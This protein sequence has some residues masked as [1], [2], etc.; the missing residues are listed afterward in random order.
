MV[1]TSGFDGFPRRALK[2]LWL[3]CD[4]PL[5]LAHVSSYSCAT[6]PL[7]RATLIWGGT[8]M[9]WMGIQGMERG[10]LVSLT[11]RIA[12]F[13]VFGLLAAATVHAQGNPVPEGQPAA[14][15]PLTGVV[16]DANG[17]VV[18]GAQVTVNGK[19]MSEVLNTD[20]MGSYSTTL[21]PGKYQ[22]TAAADSF[23]ELSKKSVK[24]QRDAEST[25]DFVLGGPVPAGEP[26]PGKGDLMATTEMLSSPGAPAEVPVPGSGASL[27]DGLFRNAKDLIQWLN[28][29]GSR[30]IRLQSAIAAEK[31]TNMFVW[32]THTGK[33]SYA[34]FA[35][36][37]MHNAGDVQRFLQGLPQAMVLGEA[38]VGQARYLVLRTSAE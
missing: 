22:V 31:Y 38:W 20:A 10:A 26:G 32:V 15:V 25:V 8:G 3:H 12:G 7:R 5:H 29:Q 24:L 21:P 4:L 16:R 36:G 35:A 11:A 18:Q 33:D 30:G 37:A 1:E 13:A 27:V 2:G 9:D 17:A 19:G 28:A 34:V 23:S 6:F 14:G